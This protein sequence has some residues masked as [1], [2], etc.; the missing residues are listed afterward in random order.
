M[1]VRAAGLALDFVGF[2]WISLDKAFQNGL[3]VVIPLFFSCTSGIRIRFWLAIAVYVRSVDTLLRLG[4]LNYSSWSAHHYFLCVISVTIRYYTISLPS[5]LSDTILVVVF[6]HSTSGNSSCWTCKPTSS[7][8]PHYL[9][10][11]YM[12]VPTA[13]T[14][15][16]LIYP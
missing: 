7:A 6:P 9:E 1:V 10:L 16:V 5:F 12:T 3:G 8:T 13:Y 4:T 14:C 15:N 11:E 2:R